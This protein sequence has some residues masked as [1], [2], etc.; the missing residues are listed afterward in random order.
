[1]S[2]FFS[3][4]QDTIKR[5]HE[6]ESYGYGISWAVAAAGVN[7][8]LLDAHW[9]SGFATHKIEEASDAELPTVACLTSGS[10]TPNEVQGYLGEL[11]SIRDEFRN[12]DVSLRKWLVFELDKILNHGEAVLKFQNLAEE[13]DERIV[14]VFTELLHIEPLLQ[15]ERNQEPIWVPEIHGYGFAHILDQI[16][17]EFRHWLANEKIWIANQE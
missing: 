17:R 8:G 11:M 7:L 6:M 3:N 4:S 14:A 12:Y 1:M 2:Q 16:I 15:C 5:L 9:V 10:L 13:D